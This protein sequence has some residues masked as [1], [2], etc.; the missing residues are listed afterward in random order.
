MVVEPQLI[1]LRK[2]KNIRYELIGLLRQPVRLRKPLTKLILDMDSSDN[3]TYGLQEDSACNGYFGYTCY[4]P[5]FCYNQFGDV[6]GALMRNGNVHSADDWL[7]V[8]EPVVNRYRDEDI[9]MAPMRLEKSEIYNSIGS[10]H[11]KR[12]CLAPAD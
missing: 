1:D 9:G 5:L 8:L 3:P 2:G 7:L 10:I 11:V 4:H 6:E 12:F